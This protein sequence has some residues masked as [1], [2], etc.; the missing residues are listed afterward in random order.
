M[1]LLLNRH[2]ILSDQ[3]APIRDRHLLDRDKP[4]IRPDTI[5]KHSPN[6]TFSHP[7]RN[8]VKSKDA[9]SFCAAHNVRAA[10]C[11]PCRLVV[12]QSH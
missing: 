11:S 12:T 2:A 5:P 1:H 7:E 6:L 4:R 10:F 9:G 8:V 3:E